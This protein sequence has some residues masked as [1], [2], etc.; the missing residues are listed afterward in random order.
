MENFKYYKITQKDINSIR[1]EHEKQQSFI[2]IDKRLLHLNENL[3]FNLFTNQ[4]PTQMSLFLQSDTIIDREQQQ[5]IKRIENLYVRQSEKFYYDN[6][7]ENNLQHIL[8]DDSLTLDDKTDVIYNS[9]AEL[10]ESLYTN[11]DSPK[12]ITRSKNIVVPILNTILHNKNTIASYIKIIEYDYYTHTHSLNVSIYSLHLGTQIGLNKDDLSALGR[13]AL[14]HDLGKSKVEQNILNKDGI[15]NQEEFNS[16][17]MHPAL[18]YDIALNIGIKDKNI[19]DGIRHHHEKLDGRGY[20]D[21]LKGNKISLFPRIIAICDIFDALTT[22][23]SYKNAISS[24][25]A[26]RLMK[27]EMDTHLDMK[28]LNIFIRM[29]HK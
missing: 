22:R 8:K 4:G 18:G 3:E 21:N 2:L 28:I 11:P 1:P 12:T 20:P 25:N 24:L 23:R 7:L 9:T 5:K 15:L 26:L 10:T 17:K 6:F 29:L 16:I 14:L 27:E 19:L 13:A